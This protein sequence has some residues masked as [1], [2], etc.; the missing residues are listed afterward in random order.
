MQFQQPSISEAASKEQRAAH[1]NMQKDATITELS[2]LA[3]ENVEEA[4]ALMVLA[5]LQSPV[6]CYIFEG[7]D[8]KARLNALAWLFFRNIR[9]RL[10]AARCAFDKTSGKMVCCFM[11]QSP[12]A[13][14]IVFWTMLSNGILTLPFLYGWRAFT[15]LL[16]V[17]EFHEKLDNG[18]RDELKG[19]RYAVLERMV[20][21]PSYQGTGVG[22]R[23][24][25]AALSENA[26]QGYGVYLTTQEERNVTFYS[27]LG[28]KEVRRD[29]NYPFR[30]S[31]SSSSIIINAVMILEPRSTSL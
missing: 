9:L 7:L 4:A 19:R 31:S 28:F 20:V 6:Y 16:E 8:E 22:S 10:S 2:P 14:D 30:K 27:R 26:K 1:F 24:L 25:H 13:G 3:E 11:L 17:K 12:D 18:V 5:F 29:A 15:R 21:A 23:C